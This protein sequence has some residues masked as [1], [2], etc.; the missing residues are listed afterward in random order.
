MRA[1]ADAQQFAA[2]LEGIGAGEWNNAQTL[3]VPMPPD[4]CM[5]T[6]EEVHYFQKKKQRPGDRLGLR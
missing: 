3:A 1:A 5:Q 6:E 2:D 4:V